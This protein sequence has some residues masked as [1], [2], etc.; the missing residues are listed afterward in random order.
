MEEQRGLRCGE[1][2]LNQGMGGTSGQGPNAG[3]HVRSDRNLVGLYYQRFKAGSEAVTSHE[4][5]MGF[6]EN[7]ARRHRRGG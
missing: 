4:K 5:R 3:S 1:A 6:V 2:N 7:T